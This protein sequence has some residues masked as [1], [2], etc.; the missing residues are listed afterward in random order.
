MADTPDTPVLRCVECGAGTDKGANAIIDQLV[1][2]EGKPQRA[3]A[4]VRLGLRKALQRV[5]NLLTGRAYARD[6]VP[7]RGKAGLAMK[8]RTFVLAP[9]AAGVVLLGLALL[10]GA[11]GLPGGGVAT[12]AATSGG[13]TNTA[14]PTILGTA[15]EGE[16]LT[17]TNGGW[18][19]SGTIS[20]GYQWQ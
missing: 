3:A 11:A 13:P 6:G 16:T 5:H 17:A 10:A 8:A 2:D 4:N 18:S 19:G 15:Q 7:R 1:Q 20:Y 12:A 9:V 14:R